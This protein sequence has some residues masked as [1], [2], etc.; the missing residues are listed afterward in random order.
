MISKS[1]LLIVVMIGMMLCVQSRAYPRYIERVDDD[2][3]D[4]DF[5]LRDVDQIATP[6]GF[7]CNG[8]LDKNEYQCN[9][10]CKSNGFKGG[11]CNAL[12]GW[13]RCDCY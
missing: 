11:Y 6:R 8:P 2:S 12:T 13:L 5:D 7:G 3:N 1:F 10:H 9:S 4:A